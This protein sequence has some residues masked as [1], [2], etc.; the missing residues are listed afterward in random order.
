M[1][2]PSSTRKQQSIADLRDEI[3]ADPQ[4]RSD[5]VSTVR[6][7]EM[8]DTLVRT[9]DARRIELGISKAELSRRI[10]REP[11]TVRRLF[12]AGG[13][14]PEITFLAEIAEAVGMQITLAPRA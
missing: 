5:Y 2:Q 8:V 3:L 14:N 6:E 1:N 10:A 7:I 4:G 12:T 11:S 9:L 13:A